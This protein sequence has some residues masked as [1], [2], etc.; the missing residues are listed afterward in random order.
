MPMTAYDAGKRET[1]MPRPHRGGGPEFVRFFAPLVEALRALGESGRPK[2][3]S[4]KIADQLHIP[5]HELNRTNKNGESRF[6]N[7]VAWA[8]FYLAKAGLIDTS[9]RGVWALTEQGRQS[10]LDCDGALRIFQEVQAKVKAA[11]ESEVSDETQA[12]ASEQEAASPDFREAMTG[13]LREL[14][15][16]GFERLC[17]RVLREVG[18]EELQVRGRS[19]DGGIDGVGILRIN[20]VLAD[21]VVFQCKRYSSPVSPADVRDFRGAMQGRAQRGIFLATSKFSTEATREAMREGAS[22]IDLVD[23]DGLLALLT[24]YRLGVTTQTV[25]IVD[26]TF[27]SDYLPQSPNPKDGQGK[28]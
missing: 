24:E 17:Q 6:E 8:R 20:P 9:K 4:Q 5:E 21:R 12:P 7:Q 3:I 13:L 28:N 19:G 22:P 18:F 26:R 27:F 11:K 15:A 23:I 2:E 1:T 10:Q 25:H 14:T 16:S